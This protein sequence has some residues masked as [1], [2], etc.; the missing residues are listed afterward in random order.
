[1]KHRVATSAAI[2]VSA[3]YLGAV[4]LHHVAEPMS[5]SGNES[6]KAAVYALLAPVTVA[7]HEGTALVLGLP[8]N[9]K[10]MLKYMAVGLATATC[11]DAAHLG[12]L[13]NGGVYNTTVDGQ[14]QAGGI[15]LGA[16]SGALVYALWRTWK[17]LE[18]DDKQAALGQK[19]AV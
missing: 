1:M 19:L 9:D 8:G 6:T 13:Q 10:R 3:W 7:T 2:G 15:L 14:H 4:F 5:A 12:W 11:L 18:L 16:V 17:S